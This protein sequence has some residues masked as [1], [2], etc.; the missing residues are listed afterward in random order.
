MKT[1]SP[2][3]PR[4]D[5]FLVRSCVPTTEGR[6]KYQSSPRGI[7]VYEVSMVYDFVTAL[8]SSFI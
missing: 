2:T 7:V 1:D 5:T 4:A 3:P 6:V 8:V